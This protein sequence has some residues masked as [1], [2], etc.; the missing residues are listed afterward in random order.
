[1]IDGLES[2]YTQSVPNTLQVVLKALNNR[3]HIY[4]V[5]LSISTDALKAQEQAERATEGKKFT[6]TQPYCA[7]TDIR[8][9]QSHQFTL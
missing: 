4:V 6:K 3:K 9:I 5:H 7:H 8:R 2:V 1:M